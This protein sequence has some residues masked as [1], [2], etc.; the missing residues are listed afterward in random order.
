VTL[1]PPLPPQDGSTTSDYTTQTGLFRNL[2]LT[3]AFGQNGNVKQISMTDVRSPSRRPMI[4][5]SAYNTSFLLCGSVPAMKGKQPIPPRNWTDSDINPSLKSSRSVTA[6][7]FGFLF[8]P[9]YGPGTNPA[10]WT[11]NPIVRRPPPPNS[12]GAIIPIHTGVIN[13]TFCDGHC[14]QISDDPDNVI[15][16]IDTTSGTP[17]VRPN[18]D[19]DDISTYP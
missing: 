5:E 13:V 14:E 6:V 3:T 17:I 4:A 15:A 9:Y 18:Y 7:Q 8:W 16:S 19:Y 11:G 1:L 2:T 12:P 10:K